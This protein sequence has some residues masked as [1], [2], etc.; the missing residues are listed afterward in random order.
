[1]AD[2]ALTV[3]TFDQAVAAIGSDHQSLVQRTF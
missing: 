2:A 1:M 3:R